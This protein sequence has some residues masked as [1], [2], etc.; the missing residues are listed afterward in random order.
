MKRIFALLF[1]VVIS[2]CACKCRINEYS[3]EDNKLSIPP[4][5]RRASAAK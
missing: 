5:L 4:E 3:P 1:I 2:G